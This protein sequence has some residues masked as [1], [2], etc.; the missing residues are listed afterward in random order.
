MI[1]TKTKMATEVRETRWKLARLHLERNEFSQALCVLSVMLK[2]EIAS[3]APHYVLL[4]MCSGVCLTQSG[5]NARAERYLSDAIGICALPASASSPTAQN[6]L[7][8]SRLARGDLRMRLGNFAGAAHD[9]L[10][11]I[12]ACRQS[13]PRHTLEWHNTLLACYRKVNDQRRF[14]RALH[15]FYDIYMTLKDNTRA[16]LTLA[17][18]AQLYNTFGNLY[19]SS[20]ML[21][22]IAVLDETTT[23]YHAWQS[24]LVMTLAHAPNDEQRICGSCQLISKHLQMCK[25]QRI[26][27]CTEC[28]VQHECVADEHKPP[29]KRGRIE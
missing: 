4:L 17:H 7:I 3:D 21:L 25:C 13:N 16:I 28:H 6:T 10:R 27:F 8:R 22:C 5:D 26:N 11:A 23:S 2:D 12:Y 18:L 20:N 19:E 24:S 14:V 9:I 29:K 1:A 15:V